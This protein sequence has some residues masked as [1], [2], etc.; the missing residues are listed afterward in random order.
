M[1][2]WFHISYSFLAHP[3][4][5]ARIAVIDQHFSIHYGGL[6]GAVEGA[7]PHMDNDCI[8]FG[9][10]GGFDTEWRLGRYWHL[11]GNIAGALLWTHFQTTQ[12]LSQGSVEGY[13]LESDFN[14]NTPNLE[15]VGGA[16]WGRSFFKDRFKFSAKIAYEFHEWWD[17]NQLRRFFSGSAGYA[18]DVVSR[19]NFTLNGFSFRLQ[20]NL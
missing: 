11:F 10:R 19:G 17:M 6:F 7:I 8:G 12:E 1:G 3:H 2:K 5:G 13:D 4:F 15:I 14:D 9:V 20:V 18:N 16:G